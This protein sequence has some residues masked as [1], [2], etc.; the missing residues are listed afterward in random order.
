[1]DELL[2]KA[3]GVKASLT[4]LI[5]LTEDEKNTA[6]LKVAEVLEENKSYIL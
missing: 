1:M 5:Q 6:L 4:E 3:K 2:I